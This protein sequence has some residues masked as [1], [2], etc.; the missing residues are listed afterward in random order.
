MSITRY[1]PL[2]LP[3]A[4]CV[5]PPVLDAVTQK[6]ADQVVKTAEPQIRLTVGV[7][8]LIAESCAATDM[9]TYLFQGQD[10]QAMGVTMALVTDGP[11]WTFSH[12]GIDGADGTLTLATDTNRVAFTATYDVTGQGSVSGTLKILNCSSAADTGGATLPS[13][14]TY[15]ADVNGSLDFNSTTS[16]D[17]THAEIAGTGTYNSLTWSP[18]T[19]LAPTAGWVDWTNKQQS[20]D[21]EIVLAGASQIDP[22]TLT[23]PGTATGTGTSAW[24][25]NVTVRLP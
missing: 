3:L 2:L 8:G 18:P 4:G 13:A 16:S 12:V 5:E 24:S 9:N 15:V 14:D 22:S 17:T 7:A 21:E 25:A 20:P 6:L 19:V 1:V 11:T 23:W 10:A